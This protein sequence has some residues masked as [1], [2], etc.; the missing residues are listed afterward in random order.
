[1][2][3]GEPMPGAMPNEVPKLNYVKVEG[4]ER[5]LDYEGGVRS[6]ID[7][8]SIPDRSFRNGKEETIKGA[9]RLLSGYDVDPLFLKAPERNLFALAV[10]DAWLSTNS[11]TEKKKLLDILKLVSTGVTKDNRFGTLSGKVM[12]MSEHGIARGT[13]FDPEYT[14]RNSQD[15]VQRQKQT[16]NTHSEYISLLQ[17]YVEENKDEAQTEKVKSLLTD[18]GEDA[19]MTAVRKKL[20]VTREKERPFTVLVLNKNAR[21]MLDDVG[22]TSLYISSD[23][24]F[25]L[26]FNHDWKQADSLEHEYAHSQSDG[27][28]RWYQDLLFRGMNEAL[29]ENATSNPKTYPVQ[30][31]VLNQILTIHPEYETLMYEAYIGSNESRQS[32]FA[33]LIED[34]GLEGFLVLARVAPIDNPKM[35]G[36][37]GRSVYI[38][39]NEATKVFIKNASAKLRKNRARKK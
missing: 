16:G 19:K 26:V 10:S 36:E 30:R 22:Y 18:W 6:A 12:V 5:K 24:S 4:D 13:M 7:T 28:S 37:I 20:K 25:T 21:Q 39:P 29:T 2:N 27:L 3:N 31:E 32:L 11:I 35:S 14:T 33:K 23:T 17:N 38:E 9:V 34:Y 8:Y 1:M 15:K